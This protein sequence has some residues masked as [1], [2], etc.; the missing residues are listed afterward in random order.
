MEINGNYSALVLYLKQNRVGGISMIQLLFE[1]NVVL[2]II[3][4]LCFVSLLIKY[5]LSLLFARLIKMSDKPD[6]IGKR[7]KYCS[8][9]IKSITDDFIAEYENSYCVNNVSIFV[10]KYMYNV[11]MLGI[12][13]Y[14]WESIGLLTVILC[15]LIGTFGAVGAYSL[16]LGQGELLKNVLCGLVAAGTIIVADIFNDIQ[17]KREQLHTNICNYLENYMKPRLERGE[18]RYRFEECSRL[19]D[20]IDAGMMALIESM[21]TDDSE[22]LCDY[23]DDRILEDVI[24]EYLT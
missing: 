18:Y 23:S 22:S 15:L 3:V 6:N 9:F 21:D 14:T 19:S 7:N 4:A 13:S 10:D 11:S 17:S 2:Y 20:E 12:R 16:N 5:R 1:N 24:S 8:W